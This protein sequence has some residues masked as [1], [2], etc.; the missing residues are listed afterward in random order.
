MFCSIY[1][2]LFQSPNFLNVEIRVVS[3]AYI[4]RS[5]ILVADFR[6]LTTILNNSG[7][8]TDPCGIPHD[9]IRYDYFKH[10]GS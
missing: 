1:F 9:K 4:T 2:A 10:N 5:N 3:S 6:S 8:N 7:P